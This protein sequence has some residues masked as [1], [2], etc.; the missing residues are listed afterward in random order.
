MKVVWKDPS[1]PTAIPCLTGWATKSISTGT[2][3]TQD[4]VPWA[5]TVVPEGPWGGLSARGGAAAQ[6]PG[7]SRIASIPP[8]TAASS[9]HFKAKHILPPSKEPGHRLQGT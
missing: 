7:P 5:E 9:K 3:E 2:Q 6:A 4:P 1:E 8:I